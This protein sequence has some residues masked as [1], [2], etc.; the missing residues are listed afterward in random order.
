MLE[1]HRTGREDHK[2]VLFSLLT[3][4]IWHEQFIRP[5]RWPAVARAS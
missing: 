3:F 5:G 2:R 4:E 1:E